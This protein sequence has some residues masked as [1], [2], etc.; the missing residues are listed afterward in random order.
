MMYEKNIC[1]T[2]ISWI[3][4]SIAN[5]LDKIT[6][7]INRM[8]VKKTPPNRNCLMNRANLTDGLLIRKTKS[9]SHVQST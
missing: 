3:I 9:Y 8:A 1:Q 7:E 4:S 6:S 5:L 2:T